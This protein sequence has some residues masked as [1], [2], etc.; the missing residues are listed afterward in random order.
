MALY[1]NKP[2]P[3]SMQCSFRELLKVF[4]VSPQRKRTIVSQLQ[5]KNNNFTI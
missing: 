5:N 4:E 3:K 2:N 1:K